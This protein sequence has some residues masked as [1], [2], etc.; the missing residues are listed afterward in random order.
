MV[1]K[2]RSH[3]LRPFSLPYGPTCVEMV[4]SPR[5]RGPVPHASPSH[6]GRGSGRVGY[7][8]R[9]KLPREKDSVGFWW[10]ET[11]LIC[12]ALAAQNMGRTGPIPEPTP[13]GGDPGTA[14]LLGA[15]LWALVSVVVATESANRGMRRRAWG[16]M[17]S[18]LAASVV[19]A[20]AFGRLV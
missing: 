7:D 5:S 14:L 16:W 10:A 1:E 19:A 18:F 6:A 17:A 13:P 20:Y 8:Q 3:A 12:L 15:L 11:S 4:F 9:G 2:G